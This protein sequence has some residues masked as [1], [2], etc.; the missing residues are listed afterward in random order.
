MTRGECGVFGIEIAAKYSLVM[1]LG[2]DKIVWPAQEANKW[3]SNNT[4]DNS[5]SDDV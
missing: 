2:A 1:N 3:Q 4:D 5:C